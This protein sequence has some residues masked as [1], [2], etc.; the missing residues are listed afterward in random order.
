MQYVQASDQSLS[1]RTAQVLA[2]GRAW[3]LL[4]E[5]RMQTALVSSE[6]NP[7]LRPQILELYG[8]IGIIIEQ[9]LNVFEVIFCA[10]I[11]KSL[12]RMKRKLLWY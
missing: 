5:G 6:A 7:A 3:M 1:Q 12:I 9:I 2:Q 4:A 11:V 10:F 8:N